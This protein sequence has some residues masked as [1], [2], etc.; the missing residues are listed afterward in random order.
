MYRK[1]SLTLIIAIAICIPVL[2]QETVSEDTSKLSV[3]EV[4]SR[5]YRN[6]G[7]VIQNMGN[8]QDALSWYQKAVEIDPSFA[9]AYNDIGVIY[10]AKGLVQLAEENYLKANKLD[11][12]YLSVYSNLAALYESKR[13]FE[14]AALYWE[15]RSRLGSEGDPWKDKASKRLRDL[16][17]VLPNLK[18]RFMEED[19]G[20]LNKELLAMKALETKKAEEHLKLAKKLIESSDYDKAMVELENALKL[21]LKS[22]EVFALKDMARA[23]IKQREKKVAIQKMQEHFQKGIKYYEQE[24]VGS[25]EREFGKMTELTA[26]PQ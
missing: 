21:G 19:A 12:N 1:I 17:E 20:K 10:E 22:S 24:D 13:D 23:R 7:L 2:A 26:S 4:Q 8:L 3:L 18:L 5:L 6:K 15:K 25:A 14:K 16:A 9:I 11:P